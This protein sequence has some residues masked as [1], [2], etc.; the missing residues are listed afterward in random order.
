MERPALLVRTAYIGAKHFRRGR[1]MPSDAY[2]DAKARKVS[3]LCALQDGEAKQ[4]ERRRA[5][6]SSYSPA[7]H[8]RYLT[9]LIV[10][11][12]K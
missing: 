2:K 9:A 3:L 4:E 12:A 11:S 8:V 7:T 10:E 1:D 5:G 6:D